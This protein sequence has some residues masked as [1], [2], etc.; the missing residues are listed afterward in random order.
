MCAKLLM[1]FFPSR[2]AL[3]EKAAFIARCSVEECNRIVEETL[4]EE[5][6]A[7]AQ[8]ILD[9]ELRRVCKFIKRFEELII[10]LNV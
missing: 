7:M 8:E 2:L 5:L 4:A 10:S 3:E 1:L 9:N 6:A